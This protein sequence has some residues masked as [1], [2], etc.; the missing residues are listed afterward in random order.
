[1]VAIKIENFY[2]VVYFATILASVLCDEATSLDS[3]NKDDVFCEPGFLI[4]ESLNQLQQDDS[5]LI[6]EIR[7]RLMPIPPFGE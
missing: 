5:R 4:D 6:E 1:M 7:K 2:Y 3:C